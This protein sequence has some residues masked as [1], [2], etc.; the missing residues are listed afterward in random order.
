MVEEL[1]KTGQLHPME[2]MRDQYL[3]AQN[4][5]ALNQRYG[6]EAPETAPGGFTSPNMQPQL[7]AENPE[8]MQ[9]AKGLY[10]KYVHTNPP[11]SEKAPRVVSV[12]K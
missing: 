4:L 8:Y 9:E 2:Q 1:L 3:F 10:D 6:I 7:M 11:A 5:A 12:A